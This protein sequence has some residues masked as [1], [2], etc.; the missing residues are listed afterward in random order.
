M[1]S[2]HKSKAGYDTLVFATV[3]PA[4]RKIAFIRAND[5][6]AALAL[7]GLT[8]PLQLD[9]G[10]VHQ[11]ATEGDIG[12][13]VACERRAIFENEGNVANLFA[14]YETL[15][16][17]NGIVYAHT[18]TERS[19]DCPTSAP[20]RFFASMQEVEAEIAAKRLLRPM[21]WRG[22]AIGW[23]WPQP[24]PPEIVGWADR[25]AVMEPT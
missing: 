14:L 10:I 8:E 19:I 21:L 24:A 12:Y 1:N 4:E 9:H 3:V 17:G 16:A 18:G 20:I 11:P 15:F 13:S 25:V 6:N 2:Y 23:E 22:G 7:M 5:I